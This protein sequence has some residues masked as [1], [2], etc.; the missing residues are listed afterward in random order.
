MANNV[1]DAVTEYLDLLQPTSA[2]SVGQLD[3]ALTKLAEAV[4]YEPPEPVK[5]SGADAK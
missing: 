1:K 3:A 5:L 4:N 2:A